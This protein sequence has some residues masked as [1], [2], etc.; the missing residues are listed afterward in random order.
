MGRAIETLIAQTFCV[1]LD[2]AYLR[3]KEK[4]DT[5]L[6]QVAGYGVAK[7]AVETS[8]C[9]VAVMNQ[10]DLHTEALEYA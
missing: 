7:I 6:L 5:A 3:T 9:F 2:L 1:F 4:F 8:Q 10:G